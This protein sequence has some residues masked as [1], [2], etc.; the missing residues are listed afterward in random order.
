MGGKSVHTYNDRKR[1]THISGNPKERTFGGYSG[2]YV[3]NQYFVMKIPDELPLVKVGPILCAG[4]T[5]YDP[6]RNW[7]ATTGDK[8]TIGIVGIGGLGT[9]GLK[10]AKALG[11]NVVAVSTSKNKEQMAYE[12]GADVFVVSKDEGSMKAAEGTIDLL[13]IT[14]SAEHQVSHYMPL[15]KYNGTIVELGLL[16]HDHVINQTELT[17][18][19]KSVSGSHIGGIKAT[20][21]VLEICAKHNIGPDFQTIT[22]D[23][24]DWAYEQLDYNTDALRFV[25]DIKKS[26]QNP[27]FMP[28]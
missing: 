19:R 26:L 13:L 11:H 25:I 5:M 17:D 12:K 4:I 18:S 6:M 2:S 28:K 24:L 20:E 14:V 8:K 21:E 27:D 16:T 7:G 1:Y 15:L 9:M 3:A 23:Q 22:A 10:L